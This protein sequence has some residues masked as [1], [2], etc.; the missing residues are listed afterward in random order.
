MQPEQLIAQLVAE[1]LGVGA[2]ALVVLWQPKH[3]CRWQHCPHHGKT[4]RQ[5]IQLEREL[6]ERNARERPDR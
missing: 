6:Q 5:E 3:T 2:F 1:L 4:V